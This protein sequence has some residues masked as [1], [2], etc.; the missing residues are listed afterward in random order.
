MNPTTL[1]VIVSS[2]FAFIFIVSLYEFFHNILA[3]LL[4]QLQ[5]KEGERKACNCRGVCDFQGKCQEG[6]VIYSAK[7][8]EVD[9]NNNAMVYIGQTKNEVKKRVEQHRYT[10]TTPKKI[11]NR[12]G[13]LVSIKEQIEE[14]KKKSELSKHIWGLKEQ[15]KNYRISWKIEK[16]A[17]T[18]QIGASEC[19]LC[20]REKKIVARADPNITLNSRNEIFHKCREK[21]KFMLQNFL[22][23]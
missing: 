16:K 5:K 3:T 17:F 20:P 15:K 23:P 10:F 11:L 7:V 4:Y 6:P 22:P 18:Y 14:K 9:S 21:T 12:K 1:K 19:N 13:K 8:E 2:I